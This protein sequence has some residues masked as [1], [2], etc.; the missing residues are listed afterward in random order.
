MAAHRTQHG[1]LRLATSFSDRLRKI[2]KQHRKPQPCRNAQHET[3]IA[4]VVDLAKCRRDTDYGGEDA[5]DKHH[6]HHRIP[7][8]QSGVQLR[9]RAAQCCEHERRRQERRTT[10][11][12]QCDVIHKL[13][14]ADHLQVLDHGAEHQ[15]RHER[16]GA[17]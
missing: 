3:G 5:A 16:E 12:R 10:T 9:E 7:E 8:L 14:P 1:G 15:R 4:G 2:R 13:T 11:G 17:H 6:E